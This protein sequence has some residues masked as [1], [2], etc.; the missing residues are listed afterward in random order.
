MIALLTNQQVT[1]LVVLLLFVLSIVI[2]AMTMVSVIRKEYAQVVAQLALVQAAMFTCK[3]ATEVIMK[4][5]EKSQEQNGFHHDCWKVGRD[6]TLNAE[7][8]ISLNEELLHVLA[9]IDES[10]L[11]SKAEETIIFRNDREHLQ[12]NIRMFQALASKFNTKLVR[13]PS[14]LIANAQDIDPFPTF[15]K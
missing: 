1:L 14:I 4:H 13:F 9:F 8:L 2:W 7:Q 5:F 10:M 15:P 11:D 12:A 6:Q 3:A